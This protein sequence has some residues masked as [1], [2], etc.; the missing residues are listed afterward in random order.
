MVRSSQQN[1]D[2]RTSTHD[3]FYKELRSCNPPEFEYTDYVNLLKSGLTTEQAVL[4]SKPSE[5]PATGMAMY[6]YQ[7]Q[8]WKQE[9]LI[10]FKKL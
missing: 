7:Q 5:P 2:Y 1:A 4:K 10:W 9:Q 6:Q 3:A 8:K